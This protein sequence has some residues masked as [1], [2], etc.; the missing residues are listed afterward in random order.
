M[1]ADEEVK[2]GTPI[3]D[4]LLKLILI[5]IFV[6]LLL[7]LLPARINST[8]NNNSGNGNNGGNGSSSEKTVDL[9]AITN[10]IF[11]ANIQEMKQAGILYYTTERLPQTVGSESKLTLRQMLDMK[12]LLEFTDKN[13]DTCDAEHSYVLVTKQENEYLMKVY[14]KCNDDE[15]YILVHIGCYSYCTNP[16]GVCEKQETTPK[17][18]PKKP[19]T[20]TP[21]PTAKGPKCV[22]EVASG[23]LGNNGWYIGNVKVRFKSKTATTSG[24]KIVKY[25]IGTSSTANYNGNSALTITN[26]GTTKVYGYVKDSNGKTAV[27]TITV[28]KDTVDPDCSVSVLSGTKNSKGEYVG[29]VK[30]G[31][32]KKI[33][34]T[35]GILSY[36]ISKKSTPDYNGNTALTV[37]E[38]GTTTVYGYVKDKAGHSKVCKTTIKIV[39]PDGVVS[40]P[41]CELTVTS[42]TKGNNNW[43]VSNVVIGFKSKT[44]TNGA[45]IKSFGLG[46][47]EVYD[48]KSTYTISKDG[49]Y[50]I[51]GYVK[52]SNGYVATCSI[53]V[54]R[55]ATKPNCALSVISG[56]QTSSGEYTSDIV[57][58]FK[59]KTDVTSGMNSFG[60]GKSTTYANNTSYTI[61]TEGTHTVYG[62]VKDNAGNTNVCSIKVTK[63]TPT[64]EYQYYKKFNTEYGAWSSWTTKE[65]DC[66]NPPEFKKTSTYESVDLGSEQVVSGYTYSV[67]KAITA[68]Q[69]KQTGTVSEKSCAGWTYY[70]T[71]TTSTKTY[72]IKVGGDWNYVGLVSLSSPPTDTLSVKYVFVGMDW[73]RC[74]TRCTTTPYTTWKKYTRSVSTVTATDTITTGSSVTTKCTKFETKNTILYTTYDQI[75]GYEKT[76]TVNYKTVC[77]YKYRS[78]KVIKEAYIDYKW[79]KYNDTALLNAGYDYTGAKRLTN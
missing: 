41:S 23:Q 22:L 44:S 78:R 46:T 50:T 40:H 70:R 63:K 79:S 24:A 2:R 11:N 53:S 37:T 66:K 3:R 1:Y 49:T 33:D 42:G 58:G 34:K 59:Y 21:T 8:L 62:Y 31:F 77:S 29:K 38:L 20:P 45:T 28:K 27:C 13:G 12:L 17:V 7:W 69:V 57:I 36:G 65:Y 74:G 32:S 64:Y 35:S 55:D 30:V 75:V 18:T 68:K 72:A 9:S 16:N 6:L 26:E 48:N 39:K 73:D 56:T 25:G 4:F 5:I 52:D 67:G 76:R 51:K 60:I 14:L 71:T 19:S 61:T 43:Y 15:D 10:R 54:K 47:S